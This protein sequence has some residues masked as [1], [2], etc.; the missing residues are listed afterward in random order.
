[1]GKRWKNGEKGKIFTVLGEKILIFEKKG[2]GQK[3]SYFGKILYT[4]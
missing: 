4:A 1:M 2:A 3:I